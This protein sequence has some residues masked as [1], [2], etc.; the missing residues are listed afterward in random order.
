MAQLSLEF[1]FLP[2]PFEIDSGIIS[3]R[4]LPD[5]E[6]NVNEVVNRP[7]VD[8]RWIYAPILESQKSSNPE[9]GLK[10]VTKRVFSLPKTHV[11]THANA[12]N[13]DHMT[14]LIWCLSFFKG[15]R[16][17]A[18]DAGFLDA[19]PLEAGI[20]VDFLPVS[21]TI[22]SLLQLSERFWV[23][24]FAAQKQ[25]KRFEAAIHALFISQNP[26]FLQFESF[27]FLYTALDACYRILKEVRQLTSDI[28]HSRRVS[29]LC[30]ELGIDVPIWASS[31]VGSATTVSAIR[32]DAIHEALFMGEPL[33]FALHG[34]GDNQNLTLEMS[35]LVCRILVVLLG[36]GNTDYVRTP[37]DVYATIALRI[38][39]PQP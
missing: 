14:F 34:I 7:T 2:E 33:G 39:F 32:N 10:F 22:E 4:S 15:M 26:R 25:A 8:G 17:T 13:D 28:P 36:G 16:F 31:G 3:I 21:D 38:P 20:L 19:T 30:E 29:W 23:D 9:K 1:G 5:R 11:I 37:V 12:S 35:H 18:T 6:L 27:L 24:N